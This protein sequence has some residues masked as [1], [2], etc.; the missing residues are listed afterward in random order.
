MKC[1]LYICAHNAIE[2]LKAEQEVDI[3]YSTILG[4]L[5]RPQ[6]IPTIVSVVHRYLF[7]DSLF[8]VSAVYFGPSIPGLSSIS[9]R[10]ISYL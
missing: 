10:L 7:R 5:R 2:K 3:F 1:G 6:F 4:K 9:S 8:V